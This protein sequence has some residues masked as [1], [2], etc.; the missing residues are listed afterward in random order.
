MPTIKKL[1]ANEITKSAIKELEYRGVKVWR[2][3]QIPV[4]GRRFTGLLGVP[5]IIGHHKKTGVFVG[6]EVKAK[7]D[8]LSDEQRDFLTELQQSGGLALMAI[9]NDFGKVEIIDFKMD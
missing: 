5:D 2:N 8:S 7:G 6:C 3:N 1:S 4:K 9:Q